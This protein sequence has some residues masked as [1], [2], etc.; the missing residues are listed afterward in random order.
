MNLSE[1]RVA[2]SAPFAL[3]VIQVKPAATTRDKTRALAIC[4]VDSREYQQRLDDTVGPENWNIE[5][6]PIGG[7]TIAII[8]RL[9]VLGVVREDV[10]ECENEHDKNAW[11]IATAQAF[12]RACAAFGVG[13]YLYQLPMVWVDYNQ[14][15]ECIT[16]PRQAAYEI[17]RQGELL[18]D[19]PP[20]RKPTRAKNG[21]T[22][23][24]ALEAQAIQL[25]ANAQGIKTASLADIQKFIRENQQ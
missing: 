4:Y 22:N 10:G 23:R 3:E 13:R 24:A 14:E 25:G 7:A 17:Y 15:R 8:A 20:Q 5:Y 18:P 16:D 19:S 2:L 21:A 9:T 11:T 6:R 1:V 12:K